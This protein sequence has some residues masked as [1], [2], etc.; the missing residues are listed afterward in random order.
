MF[1][2]VYASDGEQIDPPLWC[3][4]AAV[5]FA[6]NITNNQSASPSLTCRLSLPFVLFTSAVLKTPVFS[7]T[8]MVLVHMKYCC[9]CA[10]RIFQR[11]PTSTDTQ[12]RTES[13]L[14]VHFGVARRT[15][16]SGGLHRDSSGSHWPVLPTNFLKMYYVFAFA[17]DRIYTCG[18]KCQHLAEVCNNMNSLPA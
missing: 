11:L 16:W 18:L 4:G 2:V 12:V 7:P 9:W 17:Y 5:T 3:P 1:F 10:W 6:Q 15:K 13:F 14:W 8:G